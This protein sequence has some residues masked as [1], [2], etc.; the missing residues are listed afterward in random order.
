MIHYYKE[1]KREGNLAVIN[2]KVTFFGIPIY[3]CRIQTSNNNIVGQFARPDCKTVK[4]SGFTN[5]CH[6]K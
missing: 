6:K 1:E 5:L 4:V 2:S 3:K